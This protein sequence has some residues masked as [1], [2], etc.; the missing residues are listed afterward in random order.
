MLKTTLTTNL[1]RDPQ[2]IVYTKNVEQDAQHLPRNKPG[3]EYVQ[4][5]K[6]LARKQEHQGF[7]LS[8]QW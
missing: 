5:N 2:T 1:A 6:Y 4:T 3:N 7:W 8:T